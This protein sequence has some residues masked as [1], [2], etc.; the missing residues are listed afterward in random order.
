MPGCTYFLLQVFYYFHL[1]II[2]IASI[3]QDLLCMFGTDEQMSFLRDVPSSTCTTTHSV[4]CPG[5]MRLLWLFSCLCSWFSFGMHK[6]LVT[7][8]GTPGSISSRQSFQ[9]QSYSWR[10]AKKAEVY[11]MVRIDAQDAV[12]FLCL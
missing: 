6:V 11:D 10:M 4:M 7:K 12:L 3:D 5:C 8:D 9:A 1:C 2:G